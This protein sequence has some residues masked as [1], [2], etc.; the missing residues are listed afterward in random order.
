MP[1]GPPTV[2]SLELAEQFARRTGCETVVAFG[3]GSV[4]DTARILAM[5]LG[6]S[7]ASL[8]DYMKVVGGS[9]AESPSVPLLVVPTCP[10]SGTEVL[11]QSF[12]S[13]EEE[14]MLPVNVQDE[15][16]QAVV[17]DPDLMDQLP[18]ETAG[19][20]YIATLMNLIETYVSPAASEESKA[21]S[22]A[23]LQICAD[24]IRGTTKGRHHC[25]VMTAR[26][27]SYM[28]YVLGA[29]LPDAADQMMQASTLTSAALTTAPAGVC[30]GLA[31]G[32]TAKYTLLYSHTA[33]AVAS[34]ALEATIE[35][36][37]A[38]L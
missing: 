27:V 37:C 4:I 26:A 2:K 32:A 3:G 7:Q 28:P 8:N 1:S 9:I 20:M 24:N 19:M 25:T 35:C 11:K 17:L 6:N 18:Q 23:G 29:A 36:V 30:Q 14:L 15:S 10:G 16:K 5:K 22:L 34:H 12:L 21:M 33:A 31:L 13:F 38:A